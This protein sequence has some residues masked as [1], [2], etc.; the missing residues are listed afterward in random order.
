MLI[1]RYYCGRVAGVNAELDDPGDEVWT[2]QLCLVCKHT[3][4]PC[5][6]RNCERTECLDAGHTCT[7]SSTPR[8]FYTNGTTWPVDD[9]APTDENNS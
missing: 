9:P 2:D 3:P 4:C 6:G 7:Y 5:C 1:K 8:F